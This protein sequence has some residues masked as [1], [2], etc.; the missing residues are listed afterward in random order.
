MALVSDVLFCPQHQHYQNTPETTL[1]D[2]IHLPLLFFFLKFLLTNTINLKETARFLKT[3]SDYL[4]S[5]YMEIEY[6]E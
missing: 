6:A 4:E 5:L 3:F 2:L 1:Q